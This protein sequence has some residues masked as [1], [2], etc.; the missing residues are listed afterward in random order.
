MKFWNIKSVKNESGKI[1]SAEIEI[2]GEIVDDDDVWLYEWLGI[3]ATAPN[4]FRNEL[5]QY[6]G[7]PITI[8]IDSYGGNVAAASGIYN[9]IKKHEGRVTVKIDGKAMSAATII[10]MAGDEILMSPLSI[11]MIH[12][13][14]T[15]VYGYASE[16]RKVADIL[17]EIKEAMMNGYE[18]KTGRSRD[19]ISAMLDSETYMSAKQAIKEGFADGIYGDDNGK[20]DV[21]AIAFNRK[22][23][24]ISAR[25]FIDK[26]KAI[27]EKTDEPPGE[28]NELQIAKARLTLRNSL[29]VFN[30]FF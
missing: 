28:N 18:I 10:A 12:N 25:E 3:S 9:A 4:A 13:P 26:L 16:L 27:Q 8:W 24:S 30:T 21:A 17:D 14:L 29:G 22:N 20:L 11:M 1:E 7:M 5:K 6:A 23:I 2:R 15:E 19:E